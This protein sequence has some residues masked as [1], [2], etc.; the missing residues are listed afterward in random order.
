MT[1][2]I[3]V[4]ARTSERLDEAQLSR[5][6]NH[7]YEPENAPPYPINYY[8]GPPDEKANLLRTYNHHYD[9]EIA[10]PWVRHYNT[11]PSDMRTWQV[12]RA[13][14]AAPFYFKP[15]EVKDGGRLIEFK[16][17]GM[18]EINP[19]FC[20]YSEATSLWGDGTEPSLLL[21]IGAGKI[22][23]SSD[24]TSFA[25]VMPFGLSFLTRYAK[26]STSF[27]YTLTKHW[28]GEDQHP[29]M[30]TIANGEHRWYKR[31]NVP[32]GLEKIRA[33]QW[34]RGMFSLVNENEA[35]SHAGGKTLSRIRLATSAYLRRQEIYSPG[36]LTEYAAPHQK[37]KQTAEKL[38][39]MRR[40]R[41]LEAMTQ[42]GEKREHW[43]AFMGKH[44]IGERDFFPKYQEEW[45]YALLGRKH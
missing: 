32:Y 20:A 35:R 37:L 8:T 30:R 1:L 12:G 41:E 19:S 7:H 31:I 38:V 36:G 22:G 43:E 3:C 34:E 9:P 17:G 5:T 2:R 4:A 24:N 40:A 44:L 23:S 39:R 10:P 16:D 15:L 33:D 42:G 28:E 45:D 18:R 27:K 29:T 13:T 25:G 6:Y 14:T 21:S 11:G 26:R